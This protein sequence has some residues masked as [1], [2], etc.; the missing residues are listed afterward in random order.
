MLGFR[1]G[2][3][4]GSGGVLRAGAGV[5]F[6]FRGGRSSLL[7]FRGKG[8]VFVGLWARVRCL[9]VLQGPGRLG[10]LRGAEGCTSEINVF[11]GVLC[12]AQ[13]GPVP[14][15]GLESFRERQGELG[16]SPGDLEWRVRLIRRW[17]DSQR[18]GALSRILSRPSGQSV[19][20]WNRS[21]FP[22]ENVLNA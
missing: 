13:R 20:S 12:F 21:F 19:T 2:R 6:P 11:T 8:S 18:E 16:A 5:C 22:D 1:R 15:H 9:C 7:G 14:W 10:V 17:G 4:L 3:S